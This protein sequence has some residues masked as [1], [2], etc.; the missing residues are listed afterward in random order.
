MT[1]HHLHGSHDPA[2]AIRMMLGPF[3]ELPPE[4]N[5]ARWASIKPDADHLLLEELRLSRLSPAELDRQGVQLLLSVKTAVPEDVLAR[6]QIA[7]HAVALRARW[8]TSGFRSPRSSYVAGVREGLD[9]TSLMPQRGIKT[10]DEFIRRTIAGFSTDKLRGCADCV[11]IR[12]EMYLDGR[13]P[14]PPPITPGTSAISTTAFP[15]TPLLR[16]LR[17]ESAR[18]GTTGQP[19]RGQA[20]ADFPSPVIVATDPALVPSRRIPT[21]NNSGTRRRR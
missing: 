9:L 15:Y 6:E 21:E 17:D 2:A 20:Q 3:G 16:A 19:S 10:L 8:T 11:E 12:A 13:D 18:R 7:A 1:V 5:S 4:F 14:G